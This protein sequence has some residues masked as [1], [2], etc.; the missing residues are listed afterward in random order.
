MARVAQNQGVPRWNPYAIGEMRKLLKDE[1]DKLSAND[2]YRNSKVGTGSYKEA[3]GRTNW[4]IYL[5]G[6]LF[7]KFAKRFDDTMRGTYTNTIQTMQVHSATLNNLQMQ[8]KNLE[9]NV[10]KYL[11]HSFDN[12]LTNV[13]RN[14]AELDNFKNEYL[15]RNT[16]LTNLTEAGKSDVRKATK[17][18]KDS[19]AA[20]I[21][22]LKNEL[23][24]DSMELKEK[25][26]GI[27]D[28]ISEELSGFDTKSG[29][30][31]ESITNTLSES[32]NKLD[33][34]FEN[35]KT[36]LFDDFDGKL[37]MISEK[38]SSL[39]SVFTKSKTELMEY[40]DSK[41]NGQRDIINNVMEDQQKLTVSEMG[42]RILDQSK[43]AKDNLEVQAEKLAVRM[44]DISSTV[45]S[46]LSELSESVN[47]KLQDFQENYDN[48]F[49]KEMGDLKSQISSIRADIEIM[50]TLL[51]N[52]AR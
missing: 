37:Q 5:Y 51:A 40:I 26:S 15:K 7:E 9:T 39:N 46:R 48:T 11:K 22:G 17:I 50:K 8:I 33:E 23:S 6:E 24:T 49:K 30:M 45:E 31:M 16:E 1:L 18:L 2:T 38:T 35:F 21:A 52:I 36:A 19:F 20:E 27:E 25:I 34:N 13:V 32:T 28:K 3:K 12:V 10:N 43:V 42:E 41:M 44:E 29:E 14:G 4:N 47:S